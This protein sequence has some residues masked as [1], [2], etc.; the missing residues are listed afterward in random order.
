M[1]HEP[2]NDA[3]LYRGSSALLVASGLPAR[4]E[5]ARGAID[6][7]GIVDTPSGEIAPLT[8]ASPRVTG[9]Y[10][11]CIRGWALDP[12]GRHLASAVLIRAGAALFEATYGLPRDDI[13]EHFAEQNLRRCG[14][15]AFMT[16]PHAPQELTLE[17]LAVDFNVTSYG[18]VG[19]PVPLVVVS[20]T[21]PVALTGT[22]RFGDVKVQVDALAIGNGNEVS[23]QIPLRLSAGGMFT[24]RGWA[25][26]F[27]ARAVPSAIYALVGESQVVRGTLGQHRP[28][29]GLAYP[30]FD[31]AGCGYRI[32]VDTAPLSLGTHS[33]RFATVTADGQGYDVS[34]DTFTFDVVSTNS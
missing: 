17:V 13:A 3:G 9:G 7:V 22:R 4:D 6:E 2:V 1:E 33:I 14:F 28:D 15:R 29:V 8:A 30:D 25:L 32:R 11:L 20:G 18:R 23:S 21:L 27:A 24:I 26:D 5:P 10:E 19:V 12:N 31:T 34:P 16:I